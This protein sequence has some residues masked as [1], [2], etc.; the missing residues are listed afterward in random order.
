M[1]LNNLSNP[2]GKKARKRVGRGDSSGLG[3]T[4]GRGEKGQKSRSGF[5]QRP[6]WQGGQIPLF[7]R[8]PHIQG[9]KARNHK[10][11]TVVNLGQIDAAYEAG[12]T[13][14]AENLQE[15]GLINGLEYG[16]KILATGEVTKALTIKT[17]ALSKTAQA[18]IEAAGGS[19]EL[20]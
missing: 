19:V 9:F 10:L 1:A 16:L 8:L 3:R 20:V 4:A 17:N 5:S 13:V 15:K 11:W 2:A 12:E 7:R 14:T 6:H 18:K